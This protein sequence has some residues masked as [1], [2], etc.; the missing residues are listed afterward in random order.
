MKET[1]PQAAPEGSRLIKSLWAQPGRIVHREGTICRSGCT[2]LSEGTSRLKTTALKSLGGQEIPWTRL[3]AWRS[4]VGSG[5][6]DNQ[7][8][9]DCTQSRR[10]WTGTCTEW[11]RSEEEGYTLT[12]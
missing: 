9:T 12:G 2:R 3:R 7:T 10:S 4:G 6:D 1:W 11:R 5:S 8:G